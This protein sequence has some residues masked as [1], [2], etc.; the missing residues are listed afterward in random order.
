MPR[1]T[2]TFGLLVLILAAAILL[3]AMSPHQSPNGEPPFEPQAA[4]GGAVR[5]PN[6]NCGLNPGAQCYLS[7]GASGTCS[8]DG[9]FCVASPGSSWA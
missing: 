6:G 2:R 3:L 9:Q 8:A 4:L 1:T 5:E 7:T